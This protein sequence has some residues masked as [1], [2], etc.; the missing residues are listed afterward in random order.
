MELPEEVHQSLG[1][2]QGM[3]VVQEDSSSLDTSM[4]MPS[5]QPFQQVAFHG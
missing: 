5:D 4:E 3:L 1:S 2:G